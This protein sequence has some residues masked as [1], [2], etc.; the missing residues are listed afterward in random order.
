MGESNASRSYV[1]RW[2]AVAS[3]ACVS[4]AHAG[5]ITKN[6][7][8][9]ATSAVGNRV[10][11]ADPIDTPRWVTSPGST[12]YTSGNIGFASDGSVVWGQGS[13]KMP[14]PGGRHA[15][16]LV[17]AP[18]PKASAALAIAKAALKWSGPVMVGMALYDLYQDYGITADED[19]KPVGETPPTSGW[20]CYH[21]ASADPS[22]TSENRIYKP[23]YSGAQ[24]PGV[25]IAYLAACH[26]YYTGYDNGNTPYAQGQWYP[27]GQVQTGA[28]LTESELADRIAAE[29][30]WPSS[31]T[32]MLAQAIASGESVSTESPT[33]SG[34][35]TVEGPTTTKEENTPDGTR[36]TQ[37]THN[38]HINYAGSTITINQTTSSTVTHPDNSVTTEETTTEETPEDKC[39]E[40]TL[41]CAQLDSPRTDVPTAE[42]N[43]EWSPMEFGFGTGSCPANT[44]WSDSLG[45]HSISWASYCDVIEGVIRPLVLLMAALLAAFI[46]LP[47]ES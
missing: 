43:I 31:A 19:G 34:P 15:D 46:I 21:P 13:T 27:G 17:K 20:H 24:Y 8:G 3:L 29:S 11:F 25:A 30:G 10:I 39:K 18:I 2:L 7:G 9:F 6:T 45:N 33:V 1:C 23:G 14:L 37:T 38:W 32:A 16:V 42:R 35:S 26:I 41:A 40:G 22:S 36:T 47:R 4:V 44:T 5:T 28:P 12:P